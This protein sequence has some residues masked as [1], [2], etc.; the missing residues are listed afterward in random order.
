MVVIIISVIDFFAK[1]AAKRAK[2]LDK[3]SNA[4][5]LSKFSPKNLAETK[6]TPTFAVAIQKTMAP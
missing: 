3:S 5:F 1:T 4:D 6:K 2:I